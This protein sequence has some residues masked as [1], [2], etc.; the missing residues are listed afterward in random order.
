MCESVAI[1]D[2]GRTVVAGSL[3]D[4]KRSTGRRMVLLSVPGDHRLEWLARVPGANL[5]RPGIERAEIEL[6]PD[7]EPD[8]VL[9]AALAAGS[10]VTHFE[11]ADPSLE[12]VFIEHVGHPADIDPDTEASAG[13]HRSGRGR[14]TAGRPAASD[15]EAVA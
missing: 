11:V 10:R 4:V 2:H 7:V 3:R 15:T 14:S 5:L 12:Q 6:E 8:A 13:T 9:A 1:V